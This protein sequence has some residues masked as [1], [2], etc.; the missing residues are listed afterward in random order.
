M[1]LISEH[2]PSEF[3]SKLHQLG[4]DTISLPADPRLAPAVSSHPDMLVVVTEK[5][6]I[7]DQT[8][9]TQ[10]ARKQLDLV[11]HCSG[12]ILKTTDEP[13]RA[14]YPHDIRFNT[15]RIGNYLFCHP[16]HTSPFLLSLAQKNNLTI[17][18]TKQGY[19]GCA[20]CPVGDHA[21]ITADPSIFRAAVQKKDLDVLLI[22]QGHISLPG[23]SHGFIGGCCGHTPD[24]IF[25]CGSLSHHPSGTDIRNFIDI[26]GLKT[27]ELSNEALFDCG[28][29]LFIPYQKR[30]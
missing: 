25:F 7:T 9:Y 26:H 23:Y 27:V 6:L 11:C 10:I 19:T 24:S 30:E 22:H 3:I 1:F 21:L 4:Y 16:T 14:E 2:L 13:P 8:Y 12:L 18:P 29:L 17:V 28:S 20:S 15:A 5:Y